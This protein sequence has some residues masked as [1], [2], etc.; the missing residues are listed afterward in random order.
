MNAASQA[1]AAPLSA[2]LLAATLLA[3]PLAPGRSAN[4]LRDQVRCMPMWDRS[5]PRNAWRAATA[6]TS[7]GL[8]SRR[9]APG[10][11]SSKNMSATSP[12]RPYLVVEATIPALRLFGAWRREGYANRLLR[13]IPRPNRPS[14]SNR[15]AKV[16]G[17]K[18]GVPPGD[19]TRRE[20]SLGSSANYASGSVGAVLPIAVDGS[21]QGP[22]SGGAVAGRARAC[23]RSEQQSL[24]SPR[25]RVRSVRQVRAGSRRRELDRVFAFRFDGATGRLTPTEAGLREVAPG[26]GL[27]PF[28]C[29]P[30]EAPDRVGARQRARQ[31]RIATYR[32]DTER[33]TPHARSR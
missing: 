24:A 1:H 2:A 31:H 12:I 7:T 23:T 21:L 30:P 14:S 29:V 32:F 33:G 19:L 17:G 5:R 18:N 9:R 22:A 4:L 8:R 3:A 15:A 27:P 20:N 11:T 25:H 13:S 16:T 28:I 26:R 10:S 6:F